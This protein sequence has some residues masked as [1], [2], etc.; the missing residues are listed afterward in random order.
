[1]FSGG[2]R[3]KEV[4]PNHYTTVATRLDVGSPILV[5][6]EKKFSKETEGSGANKILG[7]KIHAEESWAGSA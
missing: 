6:L 4:N 1:M 5:S 2:G 7:E 3:V